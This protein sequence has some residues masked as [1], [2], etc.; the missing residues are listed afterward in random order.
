MFK[1]PT[2]TML[3]SIILNRLK[4]KTH[5]TGQQYN[6]KDVKRVEVIYL[7]ISAFTGAIFVVLE[8]S[9]LHVFPEYFTNT[10]LN[11]PFLGDNYPVPVTFLLY[12][13]VLLI[14]ELFILFWIN[15]KV[16]SE[17]AKI[18]NYPNVEDV[19]YGKKM[20]D[21]VKISLESNSKDQINLGVNPFYGLNKIMVILW[22]VINIVKAMISSFVVKKIMKRVFGRYAFK[23]MIDIFGVPVYAFWNAYATYNVIKETKVYVMAPSVVD[24]FVNQL[25]DQQ[26]NNSEFIL[27][28]YYMLNYIAVLKQDFHSNHYLLALNLL[29]KFGIEVNEDFVFTKGFIEELTTSSEKTIE[30]F[31]KL[32][33]FGMIIDGDLSWYEQMK[34]NEFRKKGIF[35]FTVKQ[36]KSWAKQYYKG[37]GI[38]ELVNFNIKVSEKQVEVNLA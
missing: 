26:K 10:L 7:S 16:V 11:I 38:E 22:T 21:L 30:G 17:I 19:D 14:L 9:P 28:I 29:D 34:I 24:N 37:N 31:S 20:S 4:K 18:Y 5:K 25:Y 2:N 3:E 15:I 1:L 12:G 8:F 32:L 35:I 6:S 33:L 23:I 36:G 27:Y 13:V